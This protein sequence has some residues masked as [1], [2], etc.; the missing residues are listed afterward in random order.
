MK[1]I[2][3][4]QYEEAAQEV[5]KALPEPIRR[6]GNKLLTDFGKQYWDSLPIGDMTD[7]LQALGIELVNEDG[8]PFSAIFTGEDG[9]ANIDMTWMGA[10]VSNSMLAMTWHKMPSGRYE[11]VAY[12]S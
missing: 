1:K 8:T 3:T 4:S 5:A 2:V 9:R 6:N 11:V 10:P 12:L 7:G